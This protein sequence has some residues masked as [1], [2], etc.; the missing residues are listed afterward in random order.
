VTA[1][2]STC[3]SAETLA[4]YLDGSLSPIQRAE[5]EAHIATCEDC[6]EQIAA[7][8][9]LETEN[10]H[11]TEGRGGELVHLAPT[12]SRWFATAAAAVVLVGIGWWWLNTADAVR[13]QAAPA[14]LAWTER[15][16]EE[17]DLRAAAARRWR[18]EGRA[19]AFGGSLPSGKRSFRL[20]VQ[21]LDA[22]TALAADDNT[23]WVEAL[24]AVGQLLPRADGAIVERLARLSTHK[25]AS[26]RWAELERLAVAARAADPVAFDFGAWT[27]AG[28]L[29]ALGGK[30]AL[31]ENP[32]YRARLDEFLGH[33]AAGDNANVQQELTTIRVRLHK[34]SPLPEEL[35]DLARTFESILLKY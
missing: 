27:E 21:F 11:A 17:Q 4:E 10:E 23:G 12:R 33:L 14:S 9:V 13:R 1:D 31:L 20:G 32:T 3:P 5:V 8:A 2:T 26:N 25:G 22:K 29:A 6:F 19:L 28:R 16:G 15:L 7:V 30:V 18:D 24:D 34:R 35:P